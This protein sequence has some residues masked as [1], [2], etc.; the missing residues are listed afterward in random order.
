[1]SKPFSLQAHY[2]QRLK[3]RWRKAPFVL[4]FTEWKDITGTVIVIKER[5]S[6]ETR[7]EERNPQQLGNLQDRGH[8]YGENLKCLTPLLKRMVEGVCDEAGVPMELQ[9]FFNKDG[10][11]LRD[12]L[13]LDE[14]SGAKL[15]LLFRLQERLHNPERIELLAR[16]I[17]RFSREEAAYWLARTTSYGV[18][19]NR[20]AISGLRIMLTGTSNKDDGIQRM[21]DK[22][23]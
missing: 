21:L 16:R 11:K 12:N 17:M 3:N 7:A 6:S 23:R 10:L 4:R 14:E 8:L 1:M 9:R 15:A 19:A 20:W 22:L 18:D 13:P 5:V 2:D